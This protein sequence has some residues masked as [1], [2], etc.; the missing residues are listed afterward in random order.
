M[1]GGTSSPGFLSLSS[2]GAAC[3]LLPG[4]RF[5]LTGHLQEPGGKQNC[6][7][8]LLKLPVQRHLGHQVSIGS[9][10]DLEIEDDSRQ[11]W[12]P[13]STEITFLYCFLLFEPLLRIELSKNLRKTLLWPVFSPLKWF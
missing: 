8:D 12:A 3:A 2:L 5:L 9:E 7:L 6:F 4:Q 11:G 10:L 13:Q 1:R